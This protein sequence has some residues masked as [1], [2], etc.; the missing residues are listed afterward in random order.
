MSDDDEFIDDQVKSPPHRPL[1]LSFRQQKELVLRI[2]EYGG[3]KNLNVN[4]FLT[5][6]GIGRGNSGIGRSYINKINDLRRRP[7]AYEKL[8]LD[9]LGKIIDDP[10]KESSTPLLASTSTKQLSNLFETMSVN[11]YF[12]NVSW[13][14]ILDIGDDLG[15]NGQFI[16]F[17][18]PGI[19]CGEDP[20]ISTNVV[21]IMYP[22]CDPRFFVGDDDFKPYKATQINYNEIVVEFPVGPYDFLYGKKP[23]ESG[24]YA[25]DDAEAFI[26]SELKD[27]QNE[28]EILRN[29]FTDRKNWHK[30][31]LLC[32]P[33]SVR[34]EFGIIDNLK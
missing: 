28:Y 34:L 4:R 16:L 33:K 27:E 29:Q 8:Q 12:G 6:Q 7:V 31:V 26:V 30:K 20:V 23:D 14:E 19:E 5:D 11:D 32:F 22:D 21:T 13:D 18:T 2:V 24:L 3:L 10:S 17:N 25:K 9:L 1:A 15:L